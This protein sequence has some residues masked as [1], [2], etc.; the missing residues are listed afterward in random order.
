MTLENQ[1]TTANSRSRAAGLLADLSPAMM[2]AWDYAIIRGGKIV[3]HPGGFWARAEW[4]GR[5]EVSF[6]TTTIEALVSRGAARYT[7]WKENRNG[8]FPIEAEMVG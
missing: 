3:R 5:D 8:R 1:T 2:A 4:T 7:Q 6:G